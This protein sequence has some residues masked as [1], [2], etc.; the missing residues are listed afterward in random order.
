MR[1]SRLITLG[2]YY[3]ERFRSRFLAAAF[4]VFTLVMAFIGGGVSYMVAGKMIQALTPK[5][6][7]NYTAAQ[8][9]SVEWFQEYQELKKGVDA[10]L[11][12]EQKIRYDELND[13]NKHG[14]LR[15]FISYTD[16]MVVYLVFAIVVSL[17]TVWGGFIAAAWTDVVQGFLIVIF[18]V[19][20][21]PLG[22][23]RIGGFSGLHARVPDFMFNLFGSVTTSE[24][25]WYT[26]LAMILANLVSIIA[27]A[28]GM[29]TAGSAKTENT[30]RFG[31]IV[32]MFFKRFLMIFWA[33]AGLL[34]VGLFGGKLHDPDP[35]L[36]ARCLE[37][38]RDW[39]RRRPPVRRDPAGPDAHLS[40][41][42]RAAR[43]GPGVRPRSG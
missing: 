41:P 5:P 40:R 19:M 43:P 2:D 20:L 23:A 33:L 12:P 7:A 30:A 11:A 32:G 22:L 8:R 6:E 36:V 4:A 37:A 27:S 38:D 17:Y 16:P 14:E 15:A 10:G 18:S 26:I 42:R 28:P 31:M 3:A 21:I 9:Q 13:R 25:A 34:A 29:Q 1:R 24:Y 35:R 39:Q